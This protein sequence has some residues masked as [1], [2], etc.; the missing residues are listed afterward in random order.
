MP[1]TDKADFADKN[2]SKEPKIFSASSEEVVRLIEGLR[3]VEDLI[4]DT[5]GVAGARK[6]GEN[7]RWED[8][9]PTLNAFARAVEIADGIVKRAIPKEALDGELEEFEEWVDAASNETLKAVWDALPIDRILSR[10]RFTHL[11]LALL[12]TR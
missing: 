3:D 10:E 4:H 12:D 11:F 2:P 8:L 5:Y 9:R 7:E 1:K 6:D